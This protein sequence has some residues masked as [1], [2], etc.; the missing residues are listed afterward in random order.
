M[1]KSKS[2]HSSRS[3]AASTASRSIKPADDHGTTR[4][5]KEQISAINKRTTR[6]DQEELA[7]KRKLVPRLAKRA[8]HL[9]DGNTWCQDWVQYQKNTHP[10]FGLCMYHPLHPIRLPQRIIILVGSIGEFNYVYI[11]DERCKK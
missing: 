9:E 11:D 1:P 6:E 7:L 2:H 8:Y 10:V 5:A 4:S 3:Q